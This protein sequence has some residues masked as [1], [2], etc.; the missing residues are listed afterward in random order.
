MS[1][2]TLDEIGLEV[3]VVNGD[4]YAARTAG[5]RGPPRRFSVHNDNELMS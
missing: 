4:S 1:A 5:L 2:S 3:N